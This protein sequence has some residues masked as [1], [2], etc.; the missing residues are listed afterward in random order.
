MSSL[1]P[2]RALQV[3]EAVARLQS[4]TVAADELAVTPSAVSH[5]LRGLEEY[6]GVRLFHRL[7]RRIALTDA[8]RDY[9]ALLG[10]GFE[11]IARATDNLVRGGAGD[12]L[13]LHC[14]PSFAPAWLVPRL[15]RFVAAHPDIDLRIHAT[16]E[17]PA[18]FRS[19]TDVEIR[20]GAGDWPGLEIVELMEDEVVPLASPALAARLPRSATVADVLALPLIHSERAL[21]AWDRWTHVLSPGTIAP[22][23]GL[24]F[25]RAYLALQAAAEG[26]GATLETM[27]FAERFLADG[28]LVPLLDEAARIAA[29][30]HYLVYPSAYGDMPKVRR[31]RAWL[32][33]EARRATA[34][35]TS[36]LTVSTT[37]RRRST[38]VRTVKTTIEPGV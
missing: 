5:Q 21:V 38:A 34:P 20:Y 3:F 2:L 19:D 6:L 25:D 4:V 8:G 14:P 37:N 18:F 7:H 32:V 10:H 9:A 1:P 29:G 27:I 22:R 33:E 23:G 26:L 11:R 36:Y 12:V 30:A 24:R 31:F 13:T 28:S 35:S 15:S 16:P 17:P